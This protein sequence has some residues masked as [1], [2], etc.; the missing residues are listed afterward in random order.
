MRGTTHDCAYAKPA[1]PALF[2]PAALR[3]KGGFDWLGEEWPNG[4]R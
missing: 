3:V 2:G 1:D 4:L